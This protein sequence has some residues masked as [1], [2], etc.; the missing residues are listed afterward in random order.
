MYSM[1]IHVCRCIVSIHYI[2]STKQSKIVHFMIGRYLKCIF[3]S[4]INNIHNI[5]NVCSTHN[6]NSA[7]TNCMYCMVRIIIIPIKK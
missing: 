3:I 1:Y 2:I 6:N 5:F 4:I 7:K